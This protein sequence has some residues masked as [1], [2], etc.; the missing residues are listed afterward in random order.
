MITNMSIMNA[1]RRLLGD[2]TLLRA[3]LLL[4]CLSAIQ[5]AGASSLRY[6]GNGVN[7]IDRVKIRI[8][9]PAVSN[10]PGPPADVGATDFT[11]EFWVKATNDNSAGGISC[12]NN[13]D[14]INGNV[15]LDRDRFNQ[16]RTYGLSLGNGRLVLGV[17][18]AS[19]QSRTLCG[20]TDF[21]DGS[22]HHI[23][24]QR[25]RSDGFIWL[26]VDGGLEA[27]ADGP[28]GDISY[29]DNGVPT[30]KSNR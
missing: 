5:V 18:N 8:D 6:F 12:G 13:Y 2:A 22:W 17:Q 16:G 14:W 20:S 24:F 28:D 4:I 23:A 15:V 30:N 26:Y 9:D 7:D 11:I 19:F 1:C 21:R 10:D 29:P 25:R 27:S 3:A